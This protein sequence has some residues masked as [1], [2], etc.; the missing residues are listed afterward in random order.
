MT[1]FVL[2]IVAYTFF[3]VDALR[4]EIEEPFCMQPNDLPLEAICLTNEN[5]LHESLGETDLPAPLQPA[6]YCLL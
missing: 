4:D 5:N 3:G 6:N 1:P 2:D